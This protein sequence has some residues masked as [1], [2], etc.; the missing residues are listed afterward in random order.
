M[1][2][3]TAKNIQHRILLAL[4]HAFGPGM[5]VADIRDSIAH[6]HGCKRSAASTIRRH[7]A[8]MS[9]H[10]SVKLTRDAAPQEWSLGVRSLAGRIR[11]RDVWLSPKDTRALR[12]LDP[13]NLHGT[14]ELVAQTL[15][16]PEPDIERGVPLEF[17]LGRAA[18]SDGR[19]VWGARAIANRGGGLDIVWDRKAVYNGDS[20]EQE[21]N[22]LVASLQATWDVWTQDAKDL[23]N[24]G[25]LRGDKAGQVEL[26]TGDRNLCVLADTNG[27]Y[28][29]VYLCAYRLDRKLPAEFKWSG[30]AEPPALGEIVQPRL[31]EFGPGPVLGYADDHGYLA[32]RYLPSSAPDWYVR[33][34]NGLKP[35]CVYGGDLNPTAT[36][37][38]CD[39]CA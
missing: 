36:A 19:P 15:S 4:L 31:P 3:T 16:V 12:R 14:K 9:W 5:T 13:E 34:E 30:A 8:E 25:H 28:G 32:I 22:A 24:E 11:T 6:R 20:T 35:A 26:S 1:A 33:Q 29:Y 38:V 2:A 7:L 17:G 39:A 23:W 18:P 37:E 10:E 21:R 27:S